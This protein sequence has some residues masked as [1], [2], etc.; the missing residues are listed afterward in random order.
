[1]YLK[2]STYGYFFS[3]QK[4]KQAKTTASQLE[5]IKK[6]LSN[7]ALK[8]LIFALLILSAYYL[9]QQYYQHY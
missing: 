2:S 8:T 6:R 3:P 5:K 4:N 1:M 9:I 7:Y